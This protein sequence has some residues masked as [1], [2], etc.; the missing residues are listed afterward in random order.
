[1]V[2]KVHKILFVL[3]GAIIVLSVVGIIF[4]YGSSVRWQ[5][6]VWFMV[7]GISACGATVELTLYLRAQAAI[8]R[9]AEQIRLMMGSEQ[10]G[11]VML[12]DSLPGVELAS[13]LNKYFSLISDRLEHLRS[14]QKEFDLLLTATEAEKQN[15]EIIL[16]N[17]SEG[18]VV[19]NDVGELILANS[20]AERLFNIDVVRDRHRPITELIRDEEIL[21][22]FEPA[23]WQE[24]RGAK[25]LEWI[26]SRGYVYLLSFVPIF[27]VS[28]RLAAVVLTLKDITHDKKLEQAKDEFIRLVSHELRTP[29]CSIKAYLEMLMDGEV[30]SET[31]RG[32]FYKIMWKEAERLDR[33]V[34]NILDMSRIEAGILPTDFHPASLARELEDIAMVARSLAEDKGVGLIVGPIREDL[35]VYIDRDLF[36][37]MV[38]NLLS[39]A[40]KYTQGGGEVHL[41][42]EGLA[43]SEYYLIRVRDTGVGFSAEERERIFDKFY[44]IEGNQTVGTGLGLALVKK[45]VE[46]VYGGR[47]NVFSEVGKGSTFELLLPIEPSR[48]DSG[49]DILK[50]DIKT[51]CTGG[52]NYG[53]GW[54]EEG[55]DCR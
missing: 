7:A 10:P 54:P 46:E 2:E 43:D 5:L 29:L 27:D 44:R 48:T 39:N 21:R 6:I 37:Q 45:I 13:V 36:K 47:I 4:S 31:E 1:M 34:A 22:W 52:A 40:I 35:I 41:E 18:I 25:T 42:A 53:D 26:D 15:I 11:M 17:I 12:D 50:E 38:L 14:L 9:L 24:K 8:G 19:V 32:E 33:F 16:A 3:F 55:V 49:K 30:S 51:C 28:Q 20:L 23:L